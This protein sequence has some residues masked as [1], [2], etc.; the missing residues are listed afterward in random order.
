M[1]SACLH[2]HAKLGSNE[3][4]EAFPVGSRLA[5]DAAKG[6]LWVICPACGRWNLT[7][8][9]E[10]WE[11]VEDCE[12]Q[13]RDARR[14]VTRGE[15]ALA[16]LRSGVHLVRI[17]AP[18]VPEMAA[19]RYGRVLRKRWWTNGVPLAVLGTLGSGFQFFG[20]FGAGNLLPLGIALGG[21]A[22][23]GAANSRR[24]RTRLVLPG[25]RIAM[26]HPGRYGTARLR[27]VEGDGGAWSLD[28]EHANED[29]HLAGTAATH[30]LRGLLTVANY[31]GAPSAEINAAVELLA[32]AQTPGEYI[33]RLARAS[34]RSGVTELHH[35]PADVRC[36]LEM[37]L[38]DDAERRAMEGELDSLKAEWM[39]AE[40]VAH[41]ADDMFL[42]S[43][44]SAR[45]EELRS[46]EG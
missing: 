5:F 7:P 15:I 39:L 34:Q 24:S 28:Y 26:L 16:H 36:A 33:S 20:G 8:L 45:I 41:I 18:L 4:I 11:A 17:G 25:G 42:P 27:P 3:S 19:W 6:R 2:C 35:F 31:T 22:A 13:F 30:T 43:T 9:E 37:A 14:R 32:A 1:Y 38:H 40:E 12:R 46:G 23:L 29:L 10:R 44:L 21:F